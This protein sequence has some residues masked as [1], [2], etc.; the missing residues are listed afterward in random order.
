LRLIGLTNAARA[1]IQTNL[2][3]DWIDILRGEVI[4]IAAALMQYLSGRSKG[5]GL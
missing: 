2:V 4:N 3:F 5:V 1:I